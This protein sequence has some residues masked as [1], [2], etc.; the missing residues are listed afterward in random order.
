MVSS[1]RASQ[2]LVSLNLTSTSI[3]QIGASEVLI[4]HEC[5]MDN[6]SDL[7]NNS[8]HGLEF[9]G[10]CYQTPWICFYAFHYE[11]QPEIL[12]LLAQCNNRSQAERIVQK[13][14]MTQAA[15]S[16]C[17]P[18]QDALMMKVLREKFTLDTELKEV[19]LG[20]GSRLLVSKGGDSYWSI[21]PDGTGKNQLGKCLMQLRAEYGGSG[22][23][24]NCPSYENMIKDMQLISELGIAPELVTVELLAKVKKIIGRAFQEG[25]EFEISK[26]TEPL[27]EE[28]RFLTLSSDPMMQVLYKLTLQDIVACASSCKTLRKVITSD[29]S[30]FWSKLC[31]RDSIFQEK[32]LTSYD[33]YKKYRSLRFNVARGIYTSTPL[34]SKIQEDSISIAVDG[35]LFFSRSLGSYSTY[36]EIIIMDIESN[37]ELMTVKVPIPMRN[38]ASMTF[39]NGQLFIGSVE[40]SRSQEFNIYVFDIVGTNSSC[41]GTSPSVFTSKITPRHLTA[42]NGQL[43]VGSRK[44]SEIST[45]DL[46]TKECLGNL[47]GHE[48]GISCFTDL[49][50]KLVSGSSDGNIRI[51]D[52]KTKESVINLSGEGDSISCI[53]TTFDE[54]VISGSKSGT[55]NVWD[56]KVLKK[57]IYTFKTD[58]EVSFLT[59]IGDVLVSACKDKWDCWSLSTGE[60]LEGF[61]LG[62]LLDVM[63][64]ADGKFVVV[65]M[66]DLYNREVTVLDFEARS[67]AV[68]AE[69]ANLFK[70]PRSIVYGENKKWEEGFKRFSRM[71]KMQQEKILLEFMKQNEW[72]VSRELFFESKLMS[73]KAEVIEK[74]IAS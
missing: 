43:I 33:S 68:F 38:L 49:N 52:L 60:S 18:N 44:N 72:K 9:D 32:N 57:P 69:I 48:K 17:E 1:V 50:E 29:C 24:E 2:Q 39:S 25:R 10:R 28:A 31:A 14:P 62:Y 64:V 63:R 66:R 55:I 11:D 30:Y 15:K 16:I 37:K 21:L 35:K 6:S 51:W 19:L 40:E 53:T 59:V 7:S 58:K 8:L 23:I 20:T 13:H 65:S 41:Q 45:F 34:S 22:V 46:Q 74:H 73:Q 26:K 71:P 42:L 56:L 12:D 67:S 47:K 61:E 3:P 4:E 54:N 27:K 70:A 5:F 36:C